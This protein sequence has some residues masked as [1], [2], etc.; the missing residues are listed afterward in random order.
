MKFTKEEVELAENIVNS[1]THSFLNIEDITEN[2]KDLG[3]LVNRNK[4]IGYTSHMEYDEKEGRG[5]ISYSIEENSR[6]QQEILLLNFSYFITR[7]D[8]KI[9]IYYKDIPR[10]N[11]MK[12]FSS[13]LVNI[14][15]D[16]EFGIYEEDLKQGGIIK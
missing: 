14:S 8:K 4:M 10:K 7:S 9:K 2:F 16:K 15:A 1:F 5:N 12:R 13:L 3:F 11:S 6:R